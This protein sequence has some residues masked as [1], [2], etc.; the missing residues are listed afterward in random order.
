MLADLDP[1]VVDFAPNFDGSCDEP[2]VL[3]A[4][5]PQLLINGSQ[6]LPGCSSLCWSLCH[7]PWYAC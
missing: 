5:L 3:P 6:V 1:A 2:T 4:R 7:L